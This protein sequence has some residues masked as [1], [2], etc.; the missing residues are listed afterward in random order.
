[1]VTKIGMFKVSYLQ[2]LEKYKHN[3]SKKICICTI[4]KITL[5]HLGNQKKI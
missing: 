3:D 5:K 4:Q 2:H 1:M